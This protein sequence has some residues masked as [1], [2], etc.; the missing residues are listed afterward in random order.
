VVGN[1]GPFSVS[2]WVYLNSAGS[3]DQVALSQAGTDVSG[4][5]LGYAGSCRCWAFTM[6]GSDSASPTTPVYQATSA[7]GT[8]TAGTW[9]QLTGVFDPAQVNPDPG[10]TLGVN[11]QGALDLYVDGTLAGQYWGAHVWPAFAPA[12]GVWRLGGDGL[13][14]S[15]AHLW[16]GQLSEAC[17]FY[18]ALATSDVSTLHGSGGCGGLYAVYP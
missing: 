1:N 8:A 13:T 9:T 15:G 4:F 14:S 18:G 10:C 5:T 6:P 2:A 3:A 16:G 12:L 7:A 11:C 17:A